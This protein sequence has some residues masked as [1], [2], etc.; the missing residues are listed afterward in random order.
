M[1]LHFERPLRV[2]LPGQVELDG[3][4]VVNGGQL[5]GKFH[6]HDRPD[7]LNDFAFV[8]VLKIWF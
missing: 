1:L 8:H 2:A 6:V 7:D 5:A 3:E 4:R